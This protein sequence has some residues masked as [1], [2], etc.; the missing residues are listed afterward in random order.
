MGY[1]VRKI[2]EFDQ[3]D[4][5]P[6]CILRGAILEKDDGKQMI[7]LKL[8]NLGKTILTKA[9]VKITCLGRNE[10]I[11]GIQTYT[12]EN[13]FVAAE[14][15]FGTDVPIPLE[16][17]D[18]ET[19]TVKIVEAMDDLQVNS[20]KIKELSYGAII[21]NVFAGIL[22]F[23]GLIIS[24]GIPF[25]VYVCKNLQLIPAIL[26]TVTLIHIYYCEERKYKTLIYFDVFFAILPGAYLCWN[27]WAKQHLSMV[28]GSF[29]II[30]LWLFLLCI[31]LKKKRKE[32]IFIIILFAIFTVGICYRY[33]ALRELTKVFT[34][35]I[36]D[37]HVSLLITLA[38]FGAKREMVNMFNIGDSWIASSIWGIYLVSLYKLIKCRFQL[39]P[40]ER[41]S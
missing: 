34:P 24:I 16:Y 37:F 14:K 21:F 23:L 2:I 4:K 25:N 39:L 15:V 1:Q 22:F 10:N 41:R 36:E 19:F 35:N 28:N 3:K 20:S 40:L 5:K 17:S 18:T 11:L 31:S 6:I 9:T 32:S 29:M 7:Q 33:I 13:L 26:F 8:C 12:Y 30:F 38:P 27:E